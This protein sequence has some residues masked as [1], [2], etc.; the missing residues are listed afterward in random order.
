MKPLLSPGELIDTSWDLYRNQFKSFMSLSGWLVIIAILHVI[1]WILYPQAG[2]T[3]VY[4]TLRPQEVAG[5][6]LYVVTNYVISPLFGFWMFIAMVRASLR[7][8][9]NKPIELMQMVTETKALF[10]PALIVTVFVGLMITLAQIIT[11]GPVF[12]LFGIGNW[13]HNAILIGFADILF[14]F[15]AIASLVLTCRWIL[16]YFMAPY[17]CVIDGVEKKSALIQS[18]LLVQGRFWSTLIRIVLP[19]FVFVLFG[20]G[21]AAIAT[22][23]IKIFINGATGMTVDQ[24][25]HLLTIS[26]NVL[27][28]LIAIFLNPLLIL[29]DVILYKN[30]KGEL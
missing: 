19:K 14:V 2:T 6:I 3:S 7:V 24:S 9:A 20:I 12:L 11:T 17:V 28:V 25:L 13:V 21:F 29:S 22:F 26:T 23:M 8:L 4:T 16:N 5:V 10:V 1:A 15:A 30:L 18:R 27:S